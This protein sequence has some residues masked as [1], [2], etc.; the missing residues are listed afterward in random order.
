MERRVAVWGT[1]PKGDNE[2]LPVFK[3]K[4]DKH[5][6]ILR[7]QFKSMALTKYVDIQVVSIMCH[8]LNSLSPENLLWMDVVTEVNEIRL[9]RP[10][11]ALRSSFTQ[12]DSADLKSD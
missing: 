12:L 8:I 7:Y 11:A 4:G 1:I 3:L 10:G 9:I 2:W 6:E 5:L